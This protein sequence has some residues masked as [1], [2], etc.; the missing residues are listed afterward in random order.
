[1]YLF[2]CVC[3]YSSGLLHICVCTTGTAAEVRRKYCI[4]G[5]GVTLGYELLWGCWERNPCPLKEH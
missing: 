2:V 5:T 3:V 4:P 1:M